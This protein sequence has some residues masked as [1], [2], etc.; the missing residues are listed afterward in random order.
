M[1]ALA[2]FK[3]QYVRRSLLPQCAPF[4]DLNLVQLERWWGGGVYL[5][6]RPMLQNLRPLL[7]PVLPRLNQHK[8]SHLESKNKTLS[9]A[10]MT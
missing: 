7:S 6:L 2:Q 10:Y 9:T 1:D 5:S 4:V 8:A 3:T